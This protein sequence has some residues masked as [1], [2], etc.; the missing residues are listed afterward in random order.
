MHKKLKL[1]YHRIVVEKPQLA[2][3]LYRL[4]Q[5]KPFNTCSKKIRGKNN[6]II[7]K[8][9]L[10]SKVRFN[11]IGD[12]NQIMIESGACL[13]N[14]VFYI[15]GSRHRIHIGKNCRINGSATFWFEDSDGHLEIGE[16]TTVEDAHFAV[17]EPHSRIIV[18]KDCMLSS[19]IELRTGD[20]HSILDAKSGRRLNFARDICI[21]DHVWIGKHVIILKGVEIGDHSV[22][23]T[24]SIVTKSFGS[25]IAIG[26]NPAKV[27]R[28][29]IT[30]CRERITDLTVE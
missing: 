22:V 11:I 12:E 30:W 3:L 17:T 9:A 13:N 27:L 5:K 19:A 2:F 25:Q 21:G 23:A 29:G 7:Y 15:R 4:Y 8:N 26:G 16:G 24:G 10:L 14:V 20:S 18:G 6:S 28:E 1:L